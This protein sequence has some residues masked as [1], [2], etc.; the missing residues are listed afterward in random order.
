MTVF[1]LHRKNSVEVKRNLFLEMVNRSCEIQ[2]LILRGKHVLHLLMPTP[3][4]VPALEHLPHL[5][6]CFVHFSSPPPFFQ[7]YVPF[8][9]TYSTSSPSFSFSVN[10][11]LLSFLL[12]CESS[13]PLLPSSPE[14]SSP[15]SFLHLCESPSPLSFPLP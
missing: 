11:P 15:L 5:V 12:L 10:L 14:S 13:S 8:I 7:H 2:F 9:L 6:S 1:A 4:P 3:H